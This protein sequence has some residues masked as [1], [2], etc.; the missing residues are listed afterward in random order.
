MGR[1]GQRGGYTG[2]PPPLLRCTFFRPSL[3]MCA[4]CTKM[5][6][7]WFLFVFVFV[8]CICIY[9]EIAAAKGRVIAAAKGGG[10]ESSTPT[11]TLRAFYQK[12][13]QKRIASI[14]ISHSGCCLSF[15]S[16]SEI[17]WHDECHELFFMSFTALAANAISEQ[18]SSSAY[19]ANN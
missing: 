6:S 19:K 11:P 1:Y 8:W 12:Q 16:E 17:L 13:I 15:C 5:A 10:G 7:H 14:L 2:P 3:L 4:S 18:C 9:C